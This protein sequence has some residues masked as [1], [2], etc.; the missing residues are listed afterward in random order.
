MLKLSFQLHGQN[1]KNE[2]ADQ[3][4]ALYS[5]P[6]KN[7]IQFLELICVQFSFMWRVCCLKKFYIKNN[8]YR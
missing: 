4:S 7:P 1:N 8:K 5:K 2:P 6:A 3:Q